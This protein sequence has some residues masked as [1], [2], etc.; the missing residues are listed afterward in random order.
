MKAVCATKYGNPEVLIV[1][2]VSKPIPGN[3]DI[4]IKNVAASIT[5]ADSMMRRGTPYFVRLFLGIFKP[6]NPITGTGFAG[7]IEA[8]GKDVNLFKV[9]DNVFGETTIGFSANAQYVCVTDDDIILKKPQNISFEEAAPICDGALTSYNFITSLSNVKKGQHILINGASGSLG[10]AAI[11]IAKQ[12]GAQVTAVCSTR[13]VEL[14]KNLGADTV[15][16]YTKKDF[17][18]APQ[19][20]DFVY[21]TIGK[22][23]FQKCKPVLTKNGV[24]MSPVLNCKLLFQMLW[25]SIFSNKKAKFQAT[26]LRSKEELKKLLKALLVTLEN[27]TVKL[28]IDKTY[29]IEKVVDA[30]RLIESGRK[31]GNVVLVFNNKTTE[32]AFLK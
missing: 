4:L 31:R 25:T 13:N 28:V 22:S 8:V 11:Q 20:Y 23:T 9:G 5:T 30:H 27:K 21:D 2:N 32:K 1:K 12:I 10:T 6:K 17:T 16:D 24:Y 7:I 14:V 3:K 18:K 19:T 29:T 15:I 26:G